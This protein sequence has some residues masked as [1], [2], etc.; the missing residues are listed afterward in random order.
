MNATFILQSLKRKTFIYWQLLI[1]CSNLVFTAI[2]MEGY[3]YPLVQMRQRGSH[4]LCVA[5][6]GFIQTQMSNP[7]FIL[8]NISISLTVQNNGF[9]WIKEAVYDESE[10]VSGLELEDL[11]LKLRFFSYCLPVFL[12]YSQKRM[13]ILQ[14]RVYQ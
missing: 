1:T 6:L 5:G 9:S 7:E 13:I 11:G 14:T 2:L 3:Y 12:K 4:S 10:R 8:L